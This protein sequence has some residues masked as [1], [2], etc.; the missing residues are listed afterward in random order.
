VRHFSCNE[1][2]KLDH[3]M[4]AY[5]VNPV[6]TIIKNI[7]NDFMPIL[8]EIKIGNNV[9]IEISRKQPLIRNE[10]ILVTK[11]S[12]EE[13]LAPLIPVAK[14]KLQNKILECKDGDTLAIH[15]PFVVRI[16]HDQ[17]YPYDIRSQILIIKKTEVVKVSGR[18]LHSD[19][20]PGCAAF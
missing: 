6:D 11:V 14:R 15:C 12:P 20:E 3:C 7:T 2:D 10:T 13:D 5:H 9:I 19:W 16:S 4:N 8:E 18:D 17:E 1:L